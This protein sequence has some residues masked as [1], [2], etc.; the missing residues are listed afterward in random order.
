M[1]RSR[2]ATDTAAVNSW[3]V[4][5]S[6]S[7][8]AFLAAV[9]ASLTAADASLTARPMTSAALIVESTVLSPTSFSI[10]SRALVS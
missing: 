10:L 7:V 8:I 1:L 6:T 4:R 9:A 5:V 2:L 3:R